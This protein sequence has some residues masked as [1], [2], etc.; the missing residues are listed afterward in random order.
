MSLADAT[1]RIRITTE[2]IRIFGLIGSAFLI[3]I[4][5]GVAA[6]EPR[7]QHDITTCTTICAPGELVAAT[8][9]ACSC[10]DRV[11]GTATLRV[12]PPEQP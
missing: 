3:G 12:N 4:I 2:R 9:W 5:L 6:M 7:T 1:E 10:I 8:S 11:A